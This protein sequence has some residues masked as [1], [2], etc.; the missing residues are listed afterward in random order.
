LLLRSKDSDFLGRTDFSYLFY[1]YKN[2]FMNSIFRFVYAIIM[3]ACF[4]AAASA[5]RQTELYIDNGFGTF[6]TISTPGNGG[7]VILPASGTLLTTSGG[8]TISGGALWNGSIIGPAYGGVGIDLSTASIGSL[9]YVPTTAGTWDTLPAGNS[10]YVLTS[11]GPNTAP[12]WQAASGGGPSN[13]YAVGASSG[14]PLGNGG[15]I[16]GSSTAVVYFVNDQATINLPSASHAGQHLILIDVGFNFSAFGIIA[17]AQAGQAVVEPNAA[18]NGQSSG[19]FESLDL[20]SNGS[21]L[22]YLQ[23]N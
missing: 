14:S 7:S 12:T 6:T 11:N 16:S 3:V 4:S 10:T 13:I 17:K 15:S 2:S 19:R 1:F 23:Q 21:G 22:W 18:S 20:I 8:G 9:L 5:Q